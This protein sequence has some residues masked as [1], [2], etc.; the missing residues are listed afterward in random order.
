MDLE[1]EAAWLRSRIIRLRAA[2]RYAVEPRAGAI[3]RETIADMEER[4][5]QLEAGLV[6]RARQARKKPPQ[7]N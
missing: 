5:E 4:L 7:S 1:P 2:F 6:A 3:L